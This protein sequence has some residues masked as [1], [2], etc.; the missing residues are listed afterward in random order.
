MARFFGFKEKVRSAGPNSVD[1]YPENGGLEEIGGLSQLYSP[2]QDATVHVR[3]IADV[4]QEMGKLTEVQLSELRHAQ[5]TTDGDICKIIAEKNFAEEPDISMARASLYGFEF[6]RIEPDQVDKQ[7]LSKLKLDYIKS[8]RIMPVALNG[9]KLVVA[10]SHPGDLF[11]IEDV[12]RQ[13]Q[14][15]LETVV[16]LDEDIDKV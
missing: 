13:T 14:M 9:E 11:V 1:D 5:E 4:L 16:C 7:T 12:K 10:T 8:N 3:D 15:S 2:E 6:R